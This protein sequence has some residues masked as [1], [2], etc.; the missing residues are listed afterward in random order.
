[1]YTMSTYPGPTTENLESIPAV[2]KARK[3]WVLW[4]GY[5]RAN[6]PG[7]IDKV[8]V[9]PYHP[10]EK[11][12][13]T[14]ALTWSSYDDA[15]T[16]WDTIKEEWEQH[17]ATPYLGSGIGYVTT[18]DDPYVGIDLDNCVDAI[19]G[20]IAPWAQVYV[21]RLASYTEITVSAEGL[22]IWVMADLPPGHN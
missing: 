19:T 9:N 15:V 11:A 7:K 6:K 20:A 12:S 13:S 10:D 21:D 17:S 14:D 1:G 2:L 8:P 22:R 16:A 3:Q 5:P 18:P 4:R